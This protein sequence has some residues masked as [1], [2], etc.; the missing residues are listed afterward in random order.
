MKTQKSFYDFNLNSVEERLERSHLFPKLTG[1]Y[2]ALQ[3]ELSEAEYQA[4][5]TSEKESLRQFTMQTQ[6]LEPT[7]AE[8]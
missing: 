8:A 2:L 1:F 3:E 6:L 5:Y 4:F 7:C